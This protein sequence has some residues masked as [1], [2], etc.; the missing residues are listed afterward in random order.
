MGSRDKID[1]VKR[2]LANTKTRMVLIVIMGIFITVLVIAYV[3]FKRSQAAPAGLQSAVSG[4]PEISSIP[5]MGEPTREY[6]KLQEQQN[7]ELV[8]LR[9][10]Q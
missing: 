9:F 2:A 8:L 1:N 5:G 3:K 4:A 10:Q 7:L 6:A